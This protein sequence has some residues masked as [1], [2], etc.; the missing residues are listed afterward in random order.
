MSNAAT[1]AAG[2]VGAEALRELVPAALVPVAGAPV[3]GAPVAAPPGPEAEPV[4]VG[5]A[6]PEGG[7]DSVRAAWV[8]CLETDPA[9]SV[10]AHPDLVLRRQA[11]PGSAPA[12]YLRRR[13]DSGELAA[14]AGL[15][16]R[17]VRFRVAPGLPLRIAARGY[18]VLG[19]TCAGDHGAQGTGEF[20][21]AMVG[22]LAGGGADCVSFDELQVGSPLWQAALG[23]AGPKVSVVAPAK[24]QTHWWVRFPENPEDY[25]KKFS[26]KS[27]NTLSRKA[28]K[29]EH[30]FRCYREPAEVEEL[31]AKSH[32]VSQTTWQSKRLGERVKNS[33]DEKAYWETLA[34]L[35]A[36]RAYVLEHAARPVAFVL[37][38]QWNGRFL[39]EEPGYDPAFAAQSPGSVLLYRLIQDLIERDTP[40]L[41]D[42][43]FGDVEYKRQFGNEQTESGPL[44]LIRRTAKLTLARGLDA[45][46]DRARRGARAG[47]EA[48]RLLQVVRK[49]YRR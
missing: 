25:W 46:S 38:V 26:G 32:Q 1:V 27:R 21:G 47:L 8:R 43:G 17:T 48:T 2:P 11:L 14:V 45:L 39:Y 37:G 28:K 13:K 41:I 10:Y 19:S 23:A 49:L 40:A 3:S 16:P 9:S 4:W 15:A 33:A 29:F 12:V 7:V 6:P 5:E 31:L 30:T 20:V 24:P 18:R 44:L 42:F 22:L 36:L 34:K 35:G